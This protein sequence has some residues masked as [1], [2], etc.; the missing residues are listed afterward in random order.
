MLGKT[1][2]IKEIG[3]GRRNKT[4]ITT[5]TNN[6]N[7]NNINHYDSIPPNSYSHIVAL[8]KN[9]LCTGQGPE[10]DYSDDFEDTRLELKA[11][12]NINNNNNN[13]NNNN[14]ILIIRT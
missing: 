2:V 5:I 12:G 13:N 11:T 1:R 4:N 3:P 8:S 9:I 14:Q 7:N 10:L 6:S